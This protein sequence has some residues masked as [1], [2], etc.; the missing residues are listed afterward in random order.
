LGVIIGII[1]DHLN[2][3]NRREEWKKRLDC[4]YKE[5]KDIVES[6]I[7]MLNLLTAVIMLVTGLYIQSTFDMVISTEVKTIILVGMLIY[8]ILR[9]E[10]VL[11]LKNSNPNP[12]KG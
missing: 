8:F 6:V 2:L 10:Q 11:T 12:A 5:R 1:L 7:R 3:N 4:L 9:L